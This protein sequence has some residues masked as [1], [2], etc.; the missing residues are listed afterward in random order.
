M[1]TKFMSNPIPDIVVSRL[2]EYYNTLKAMQA[3]GKQ[4]TSS[5]ELGERLGISAAQIRKDLSQFGEFGKQG[6]GYLISFL[7]DQLQTI[8]NV[9]RSWDVAVVGAG[10]LGKAIAHYH[11]FAPQGFNIKLVFDNNPEIIGT[12]VGNL[13]VL[14]IKDLVPSVTQAGIKIA[15]ITVP[16]EAAQA[17][18]AELVKAGIQ[19]I[20]N[21]SATPLNLPDH[22]FHLRHSD[23]VVQL[24]HITY[25]IGK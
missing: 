5:R 24:Q 11:G 3:E 18:A 10:N 14:D 13:K 2:P 16:D 19:G 25:Y 15:M 21:Y 22:I 4:T 17:V 7:V 12:A 6:T 9:G 1:E 8:L 23:A 20:L